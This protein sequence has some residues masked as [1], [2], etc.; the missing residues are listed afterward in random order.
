[1]HQEILTPRRTVMGEPSATK[2]DSGAADKVSANC[3]P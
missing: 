3:T 1:M 2:A